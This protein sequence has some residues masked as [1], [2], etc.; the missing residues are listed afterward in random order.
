MFLFFYYNKFELLFC[1][2]E[3][4]GLDKCYLIKAVYKNLS[5]NLRLKE[6][7]ILLKGEMSDF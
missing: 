2:F 4:W 6:K 1:R 5:Y 7:I 3:K